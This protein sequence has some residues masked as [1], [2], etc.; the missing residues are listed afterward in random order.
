MTRLA[1]FSPLMLLSICRMVT[2][3]SLVWICY[4]GTLNNHERIARKNALFWS[5][6][7]KLCGGNIEV[8]GGT[9]ERPEQSDMPNHQHLALAHRRQVDRARG[10]DA[11]TGVE[12][13]QRASSR[14]PERVAAD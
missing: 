3:A 14:D 4:R 10:P 5:P 9:D 13:I 8:T 2:I 1:L 6:Q 7:T 11:W 12:A